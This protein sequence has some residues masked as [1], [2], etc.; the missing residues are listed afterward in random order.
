MRSMT[1]FGR[2]LAR[3]GARTFSVEIRTL[4]HRFGE[5]ILHLPRQLGPLEE[6]IRHRLAAE[7]A[8]GRVEV[9]VSVRGESWP[10][11]V[12]VDRKLARAY[13]RAIRDLS[14]KLDLDFDLTPTAILDLPEVVCLEDQELDLEMLWPACAEALD[15]ALKDVLAMRCR[16]GAALKKDLL[17]QIETLEEFSSQIQIKAATVPRDYQNRLRERLATL[18]AEGLIDETRLAQE[19]LY[20]AERADINEEIVR[21]VSHMEQLKSTL[22]QDEPVGRKLEFILQEAN[23][24]IN[25]IGAKAQNMDISAL[26]VQCK[27]TLEKMREQAQNVE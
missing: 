24:E 2:G 7:L 10:Q 21:L 25:T 6:R 17:N 13:F 1:G 20:L 27:A 26:V 3:A 12:R 9:W 5:Y 22:E 16:E 8:R 11:E 23:R 14:D 19:V 18:D 15:A 4:N